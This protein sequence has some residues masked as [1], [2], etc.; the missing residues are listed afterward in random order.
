MT[1]LLP[2]IVAVVGALIYGFAGNAK[3]AELGRLIFAAGFAIAVWLN[4]GRL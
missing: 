1:G 4:A 3:A 2:I